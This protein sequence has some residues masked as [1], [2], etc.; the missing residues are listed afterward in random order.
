M[1]VIISTPCFAGLMHVRYLNSFIHTLIG[2]SKMGVNL[3][4]YTLENES[5][6]SRARCYHASCF[7]RDGADKLF[8]IDSDISWTWEQ[9]ERILRSEHPIIGGTYPLKTFPLQLNMNA[10]KEHRDK[11]FT[12]PNPRSPENFRKFATEQADDLGEVMV[13][14]IPTGF[15]LVDKI[16]FQTIVKKG[17]AAPY[18]HVDPITGALEQ[19]YE[20][21]P[22]GVRKPGGSYLSE[23]WGFCDLARQAG[24]DIYLNTKVIT[25]HAGLFVYEVPAELQISAKQLEAT[26]PEEKEYFDPAP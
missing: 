19:C 17:L 1:K 12:M 25:A 2:A 16:V 9:A 21:F 6:I 5:L 22:V 24:F 7:L 4:S 20:F 11:Y 10:T 26:D 3:G 23:D 15:L 14:N 13:D 18:T 8:M